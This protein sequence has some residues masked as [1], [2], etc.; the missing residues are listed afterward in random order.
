MLYR[1]I[2]GLIII[3]EKAMF[4]YEK[5]TR[6]I[7]NLM[8]VVVTGSLVCACI[9]LALFAVISALRISGPI[10]D[11]ASRLHH[12][13][14][15][16][17]SK[18]EPHSSRGD[19]IAFLRHELDRLLERLDRYDNDQQ[20]R[21]SHLQSRLAFV[22]NK[23]LEGLVLIDGSYRILVVNRVARGI[24][25]PACQEGVGLNEINP[26][27]DVKKILHQVMD[28]TFLPERDLGEITFRINDAERIYRPR[29]LTVSNRTGAVEGILLLFWD[30]TEQRRFEESHHKFISML[31]H[32]LKT[33]MTSLASSVNLLKEKIGRTDAAHAEL[34]S[35]ATEDCNALAERS[36]RSCAR[37]LAGPE[38]QTPVC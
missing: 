7:A 26:G 12:G 17:V 35:I 13:L 4:S 19:E 8:L 21:F 23:V 38:P 5:E 32:Q 10:V 20:R 18:D 34:L 27:S 36:Y 31:S 15:P 1:Y 37:A 6:R 9:A 2:E 29:V 30:V 22:I 28:G 24:L 16:E 11:V 3:N 33:P 25:G 14:N